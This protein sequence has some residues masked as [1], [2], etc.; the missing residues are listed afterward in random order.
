MKRTIKT[1]NIRIVYTR[2]LS[3]TLA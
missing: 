2:C 3:F 1:M